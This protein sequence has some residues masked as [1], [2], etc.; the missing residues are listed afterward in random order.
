M[1]DDVFKRQKAIDAIF[2]ASALLG[3]FPDQAAFVTRLLELAHRGLA[4]PKSLSE[5]DIMLVCRIVVFKF[6]QDG[7]H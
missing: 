2:A 6:A 3:D 4:A 1:S 7:Q 5:E